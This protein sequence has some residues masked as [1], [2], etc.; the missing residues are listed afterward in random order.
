MSIEY[1]GKEKKILND[2]TEETL[3]WQWIAMPIYR[4]CNAHLLCV[5]AVYITKVGHLLSMPSV[6]RR[7]ADLNLHIEI[8]CHSSGR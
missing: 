6:L 5:W 1:I 2:Y 7:R 3:E 4:Y 8:T